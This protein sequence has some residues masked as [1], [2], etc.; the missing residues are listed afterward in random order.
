MVELSQE[1]ARSLELVLIWCD[2][3]QERGRT[4]N[5]GT[6][7]WK[8]L[9]I[10]RGKWKEPSMATRPLTPRARAAYDWLMQY[11]TT[12][13][14]WQQKHEAAMVA[15]PHKDHGYVFQPWNLLLH[16]PGIEVA[17]FPALYPQ[18]SYGDTDARER[19]MKLDW[20]APNA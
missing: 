6:F 2:M 11:N 9:G 7:N 17:A 20:I 16:S 4:R 13:A 1:E 14:A 3:K 8:K 5:L 15:G 19:L 12:Y 18:S 10:T